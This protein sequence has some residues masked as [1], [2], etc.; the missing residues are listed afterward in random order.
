M[1]GSF[2]VGTL[3]LRVDRYQEDTLATLVRLPQGDPNTA[4]GQAYDFL[5]RLY[6]FDNLK[7]ILFVL[8]TALQLG[9][10]ELA[11][12]LKQAAAAQGEE[13]GRTGTIPY[14]RLLQ[15]KDKRGLSFC[16]A[17]SA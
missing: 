7:D 16:P 2:Y 5:A 17:G 13:I 1:D 4:A 10:I 12:L 15:G 14:G 11:E 6:R 3:S 8:K 9:Y